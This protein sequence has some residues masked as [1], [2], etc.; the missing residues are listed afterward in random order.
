MTRMPTRPAR[1]RRVA[2]LSVHTSPLDQPGIGDAGGLNVYV[3]EVAKRLAS[4]GT[5]VDIYTRTSRRREARESIADGVRV[6]HLSPADI[7]PIDKRDL[8]A[9][10]SAMTTAFLRTEHRQ[11]YDLIHSHYWLSGHVG[12]VASDRWQVPLVHSMHTLGKVKNQSL[13]RGD[14]PEPSLRLLGEQRVVDV[15]DRLIANTAAEKQELMSLYYADDARTAVVSPGVDLDLFRPKDKT[16]SRQAVGLPKQGIVLLFVGRIQPLKGPDLLLRAAAE[17]V[18]RNPQ[19]R[20]LVTCVVCGGSSGGADHRDELA[21]LAAELGIGDLVRFEPPANRAHLADW[22]RSADVVCVP[23]HSES[24]GLVAVEAQAC[25]TPVVATAVGGLTTSVAHGQSGTLVGSRSAIEWSREIERIVRNPQLARRM[26]A[27]A[28]E[29]A[30]LF[31][32]EQTAA[33]TQHVYDAALAQRRDRTLRLLP[34]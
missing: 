15:S 3:V 8:P 19:L 4:N 21:K 26:G 24:F 20:R 18:V 7:D 2:M 33:H 14:S 25:G 29:H 10:L 30:R 11:H 32:W 12:A 22:Y 16:T 23:S 5:A 9:E 6:H 1:A 28:R 31:S 13:A 17:F 27:R 34:A